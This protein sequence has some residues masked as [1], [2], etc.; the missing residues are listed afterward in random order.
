MGFEK[1]LHHQRHMAWISGGTK[2][3]LGLAQ[4]PSPTFLARALPQQNVF[5]F[6]CGKSR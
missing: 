5:V 3:R 4:L 6:V 1:A 2:P